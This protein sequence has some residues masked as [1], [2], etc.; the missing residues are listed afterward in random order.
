MSNT[1][2]YYEGTSSANTIIK[3]LA[4]VLCTA[5]KTDELKDVDGNVIKP[6]EVII[7]KNWDVVYP[8]PDKTNAALL[9][10]MDWDNLTPPEFIAKIN[11]QV[12]RADNKIILKT[13]TSKRDLS[14]ISNIDDLGLENDLSVDS[15]DMYVEL[16][17]PTY[18]CDPE[19]FS[20]DC[21]DMDVLPYCITQE[22]Y[23]EYAN[24]EGTA[25]LNL[26]Q[27]Y[28][29]VS[30]FV[31]GTV[32]DPHSG[33]TSYLTSAEL[34][35]K[36]DMVN[37]AL[38][39]NFAAVWNTYNSISLGSSEFQAMRG[40]ALEEW[41]SDR[42]GVRKEKLSLYTGNIRCYNYYNTD[43]WIEVSINRSIPTYTINPG[44]TIRLPEGEKV[45]ADTVSFKL[46]EAG[47]AGRDSWQYDRA[48]CEFKVTR[49]ISG[50][51]ETLGDP[52]LSYKY[53]KEQVA[54]TGRKL[55]YNNHHILVRMFDKIKDDFSGPKENTVD[56]RTNEVIQLN[57]HVSEWSKLSWYQDFEEVM[58]DALDGD[59]GTTDI[60]NGIV[61]LPV[62]TPGLNGDTRIRFWI[63]CNNDR[64]S[65][66]IMG[67]PS[68]DF[69]KNRHLISAAYLGQ[70]ESFDNSIND[71]AGNF[72]L[73][74]S[75][76]TVP[77]ASKPKIKR[78]TMSD[79][80]E[81]GVGTG[82]DTIFPPITL[83]GNKLFEAQSNFVVTI[84]ET[85]GTVRTLRNGDTSGAAGNGNSGGAAFKVEISGD[86]KVAT[87]TVFTPPVVGARV[88]LTYDYY[89]KK[90][91]MIE[92]VKRDYFGNVIN[93][94]YPDTYGKNTAT[95]VVDVSMLHTRSKA[96]F[97]KH[98]LMFTTTEEYMTKEMYGKSAYT[99]EYY[100]D[101]VKI[102][103]GNDGPRG[104]LSDCLAV[105]TSSLYAFDE[106]IVNRDFLKDKNKPEETYIF[107]PITAPYSP[108]SGSPNATYGFAIKKAVK[109][110]HPTT[111]DE[112]LD[113]AEAELKL[114]IGNLQNLT[115][116]ILLPA[117]TEDGIPVTWTSDN[118]AIQII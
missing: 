63:N 67:N 31:K 23:R 88:S 46:S 100:A 113:K 66:V 70:I 77:C 76:S 37:T 64:A 15:I 93:T 82:T 4:K 99:G 58:V 53:E 80:K 27:Q 117:E 50:T 59:V 115:S 96:F 61:Y 6:K 29:S 9:N 108:F 32:Q 14:Q 48:T 47:D 40:T 111:D 12:S 69:G 78:V 85:S 36:I 25:D 1:W 38:H 42:T 118:S 43:S 34:A 60:T 109:Y 92:G 87:L 54:I 103:H 107:F 102:T 8:Q 30:G 68:L 33:R 56:E 62:E 101:R 95:G 21:E 112:W 105:D 90:V 35:N 57:S 7:N 106:L 55:L 17:K 41:I 94:V 18:L 3:D 110:P 28:G 11:N 116:D 49:Q 5:V 84:E 104:M 73:M 86:K 51:I 22:I 20:A 97:Q 72:A 114:K 10:V 19:K 79:T 44:F 65:M 89:V 98:H 16:Y 26:R 39:S 74:T 45:K 13:K 52:I 24:A 2:R 81:V 71:T 91:E 83:D 75:S